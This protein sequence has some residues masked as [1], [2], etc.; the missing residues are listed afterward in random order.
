MV[1]TSGSAGERFSD[2]TASARSAPLSMCGLDD[3]MFEIID[4][5]WPASVSCSAGPTPL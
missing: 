2:V 4:M 3:G 5:T 1:G